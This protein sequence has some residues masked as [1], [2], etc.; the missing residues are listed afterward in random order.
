LTRPALDDAVVDSL[1]AEWHDEQPEFLVRASIPADAPAT[2][3][4]LLSMSTIRDL[5]DLQ[6]VVSGVVERR[7]RA[8]DVGGYAFD[9][10]Q[11][12]VW[13]AG[14][15]EVSVSRGA[16]TR[17][18]AKLFDEVVKHS[19]FGGTEDDVELALLAEALRRSKALDG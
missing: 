7:M 12:V 19:E 1:A 14:D 15:H 13:D 11:V 2:A 6:L 4:V 8:T 9:G 17:L 5:D 3:R 16:F 18:I 10:E